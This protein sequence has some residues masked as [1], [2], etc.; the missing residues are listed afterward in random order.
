MQI[1]GI[2]AIEVIVLFVEVLFLYREFVDALVP[3]F[4]LYAENFQIGMIG[5]LAISTFVW[6][7]IRSLSWFLFA[8]YGTPT[9]MSI[10][11]GKGIDANKSKKKTKKDETE[12]DFSN[13]FMETL[14]KDADWV[15]EKGQEVLA[16]FMLPPLQIIAAAINFLTLLVNGSHMF[17]LPFKKLDD[18]KPSNVLVE[19]LSKKSEKELKTSAS[20]STSN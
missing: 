18:I 17:E 15:Q 8:A 3:W 4:A 20:T 13:G 12:W 5:I 19:T 6:F 16:A 11:Q 9:I 14:K 7:G 10:I 1:I 2:G